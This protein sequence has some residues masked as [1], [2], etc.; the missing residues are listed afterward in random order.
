MH[1]S[2]ET[3]HESLAN[4]T[5]QKGRRQE[6]ETREVTNQ[7]VVRKGKLS[8]HPTAQG[9]ENPKGAPPGPPFKAL[10]RNETLVKASAQETRKF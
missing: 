10:G 1:S 8:R 2:Q 3:W 5:I 4:G 6:R 7:S 9:V